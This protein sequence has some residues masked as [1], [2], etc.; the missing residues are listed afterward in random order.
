MFTSNFKS[1]Q[2]VI[3]GEKER[4]RMGIELNKQRK[5]DEED[6][7]AAG[8]V[9]SWTRALV[10]SNGLGAS[11]FLSHLRGFFP[12]GVSIKRQLPVN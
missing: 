1:T 8:P 12:R 7:T 4:E 3:H 9:V 2:F 10:G 11:L 5:N 6:T